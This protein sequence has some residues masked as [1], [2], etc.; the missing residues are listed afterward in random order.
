MSATSGGLL[1]LLAGGVIGLAGAFVVD[2]PQPVAIAP[3]QTETLASF[4]PSLDNTPGFPS[5]KTGDFQLVNHLGEKRRSA[6]PNGEYQLL[7]FGYARC[8]AICSAALPSMAEATDLL[9]AMG[10]DIT[11]VL[12][13][14]DPERDT[15]EALRD[16]VPKM[17][18][19]MVGLTG[20]DDALSKA[21][22][23]FQIT[24]TFV[25]EHP[26]EGAVYTHGSNIFLLSPEGD[27]RTLLPPITS[28]VRIAE[29]VA[30]YI[31]ED[32]VSGS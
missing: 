30:G 21:Y 11:P 20:T 2:Q 9:K 5:L 24:K 12:V 1:A 25:F 26:D 22:E 15:V 13:T 8:K 29:I 28:P 18:T 3:P 32:S 17:H 6:N 27:F 10:Y 19:K 31:R 23:A 7:F 4:V 14:V 16:A